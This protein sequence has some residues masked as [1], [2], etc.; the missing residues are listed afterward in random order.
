MQA[1]SAQPDV[2]E[3][4]PPASGDDALQVPPTTGLE[5]VPSTHHAESYMPKTAMVDMQ[6]ELDDGTGM[7]KVLAGVAVLIVVI[8]VVLLLLR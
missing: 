7:L 6:A 2:A 5:G 4:S 3:P 8:A 1:A